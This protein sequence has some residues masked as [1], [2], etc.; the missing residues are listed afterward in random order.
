LEGQELNLMNFERRIATWFGFKGVCIEM[1][2][3]EI[4][5]LEGRSEGRTSNAEFDGLSLR[6]AELIHAAWRLQRRA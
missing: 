2:S 4:D 1:I 5:Y 3:H 6:A